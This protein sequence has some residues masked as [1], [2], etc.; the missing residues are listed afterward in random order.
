[1]E[2]REKN[3]VIK[4]LKGRSKKGTQERN[5]D[6]RIQTRLTI[7]ESLIKEQKKLEKTVKEKYTGA[8]SQFLS[9]KKKL[10]AKKSLLAVDI[11]LTS[12]KY[13]I[14]SATYHGGDFNGVC[15]CQM[16]EHAQVLTH[17]IEPIGLSKW[18]PSC[19]INVMKEK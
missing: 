5:S 16:V 6:A 18:D 9:W 15:C 17:E 1:M 2:M 19:E 11:E 13:C 10:D 3:A 4:L 12:W 8:Q 14:S 7:M